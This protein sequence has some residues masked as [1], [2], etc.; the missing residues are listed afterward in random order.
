MREEERKESNADG[1]NVVRHPVFILHHSIVCHKQKMWVL[2][3]HI[4]NCIV[5]ASGIK[6]RGCA[7]RNELLK[8]KGMGW[9]ERNDNK[10]KKR[11]KLW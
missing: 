2:F 6:L 3:L 1:V 5:P 11:K 9:K 10:N 8:K 4:L 7:L